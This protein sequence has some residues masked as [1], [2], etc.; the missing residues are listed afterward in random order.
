MISS[1][2]KHVQHQSLEFAD[3]RYVLVNALMALLFI[4]SALAEPA[5]CST[6]PGK[7]VSRWTIKTSV[8]N[9]INNPITVDLGYL[10]GLNNPTVDKPMRKQL[11]TGRL[12]RQHGAK[13]KEGDI[14]VTEGYLVSAHCS[15]DDDD[16]HVEIATSPTSTECF[17]VEIPNGR[18]MKKPYR[19]M[20][21]AQRKAIRG[22]FGNHEPNGALQTPLKVRVMGGFFY[23]SQHYSKKEPQGGGRRGTNKCATNLWEI[24]PILSIT[25][26]N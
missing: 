24:H 20:A 1:P 22:I 7:E 23:D 11:L 14:V 9:P 4:E 18:Y 8:V 19:K 13:V 5:G 2:I 15:D 6:T 17:I 3:M 21:D 26:V 10:M 25:P 16:Y 12:A